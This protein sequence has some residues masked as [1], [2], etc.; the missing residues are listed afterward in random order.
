MILLK[1]NAQ[2][3][4]LHV[5][6]C[7]AKIFNKIMFLSMHLLLWMIW[8]VLASPRCEKRERSEKFKPTFV[9]I[10][11]RIHASVALES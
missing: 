10:G 4:K 6:F 8:F 3:Y 1:A 9:S 5:P 11:I 2:L 7:H